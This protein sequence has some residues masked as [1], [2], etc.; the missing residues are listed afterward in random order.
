MIIDFAKTDFNC[1]AKVEPRT[2]RIFCHVGGSR[3]RIF[4]FG[5][6][7]SLKNVD[8]FVE[9]SFSICRW[10]SIYR[11]AFLSIDL[12]VFINLPSKFCHRNSLPYLSGVREFHGL[13]RF[14]AREE[15]GQRWDP[16]SV[17]TSRGHLRSQK[18]PRMPQY[19]NRHPAQR[20]WV[21]ARSRQS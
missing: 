7:C 1:A 9:L 13:F 15:H 10:L 2:F 20:T 21:H 11:S 3:T 12:T 19:S 6:Q 8:I 5:E 17:F 16:S 14:G 4:R 18:L